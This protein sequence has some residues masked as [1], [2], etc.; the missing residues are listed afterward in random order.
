MFLTHPEKTCL[1]ESL[2]LQ[3]L[4]G[5]CFPMY[6]RLV[7]F[8]AGP[9]NR[10][11]TADAFFSSQLHWGYNSLIQ[12]CPAAVSVVGP[13]QWKCPS[14]CLPSAVLQEPLKWKLGFIALANIL[15]VKTFSAH[16]FPKWPLSLSFLLLSVACFLISV[17]KFVYFISSSTLVSSIGW[18]WGSHSLYC[19]KW[20]SSS[21]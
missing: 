20:N 13:P 5:D 17:L 11:G 4:M 6:S 7:I 12:V 19:Q 1:R 21:L 8:L 10:M 16:W 14:F 18:I 3:I 2:G 15:K 9:W